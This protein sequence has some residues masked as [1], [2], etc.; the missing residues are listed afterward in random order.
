MV[1][2]VLPAGL[3]GFRIGLVWA[4]LGLMGRMRYS[5]GANLFITLLLLGGFIVV[6]INL[7]MKVLRY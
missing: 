5:E 6:L 2:I 3:C 7:I 4:L 1:E